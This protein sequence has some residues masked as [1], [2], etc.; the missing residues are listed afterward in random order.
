MQIRINKNKYKS[1]IIVKTLQKPTFFVFKSNNIS[2]LKL[3]EISKSSNLNFYRIKTNLAKKILTKSFYHNFLNIFEGPIII[4]SKKN[5]NKELNL[6]NLLDLDSNLFHIAFRLNNKFYSNAEL[7]KTKGS[8]LT[9]SS[10][11]TNYLLSTK[12][13]IKTFINILSIIKHKKN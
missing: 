8:N 6:K 5:E 3:K 12:K 9:A 1:N 13:R 2:E 10:S 7:E 4:A 11:N